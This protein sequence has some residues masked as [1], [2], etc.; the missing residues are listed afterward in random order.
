MDARWRSLYVR[1]AIRL[2]SRSSFSASQIASFAIDASLG[3]PH[4]SPGRHVGYHLVG[5]GLPALERSIAYSATLRE[6]VCRLITKRPMPAYLSL[7]A[8]LLFIVMLPA[9]V[10][11]PA[12]SPA[13]FLAYMA[14]L[15]ISAS[16]LAVSTAGLTLRSLLLP[17]PLPRMTFASGIPKSCTTVFV[18]PGMLSD[19][20]SVAKL[21]ADLEHHYLLH[22]SPNVHFGLL[23]DFLDSAHETLPEDERLLN[24][25]KTLI[26]D[27]RHRYAER[28]GS[29]ILLLH[30]R[31]QWNPKQSTWMGWERKRGKLEEF[32]RLLAGDRETSFSDVVGSLDELSDVRFVITI[33][34]DCVVPADCVR[35]MIEAAAHPLNRPAVDSASRRVSKGYGVLQPAMK[36]TLASAGASHFGLL[37]T[38]YNSMHPDSPN[39]WEINNDLFGCGRYVGK[40][41]FDVKSFL[42]V[43]SNRIP[44]N[45]L[46]SHDLFEGCLLRA[47][48]L[49]D[50]EIHE[51]FPRRF[52]SFQMRQ[53]RWI[54]GDWQVL[55]WLI[56]GWKVPGWK[57]ADISAAG[58]LILL[59]TVRGSL[60]MPAALGMFII[61]AVTSEPFGR[62]CF[63]TAVVALAAPVAVD[64]LKG[65]M[66]AREHGVQGR[67]RATT[68]LRVYVAYLGVKII[69]LPESARMSVDAIVRTLVRLVTKHQLLEWRTARQVEQQ[70]DESPVGSALQGMWFN[71]TLGSA[72]LLFL[73]TSRQTLFWL[74][75]PILVSWIAGPLAARMLGRDR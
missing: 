6:H 60:A 37:F 51:D 69:L 5:E 73:F 29:R 10:F 22:R 20:D 53:H 12:T 11:S 48:A 16:E 54:R 70:M 15:L 43:V 56:P 32:T 35:S 26:S 27:L 33:D 38:R 55:P 24:Q 36:A 2:A 13:A 19:V 17:A 50:V 64:Y 45:R 1:E 59:E 31:R 58:R 18:V 44:E 4:G 9:I 14:L 68:P 40:G 8:G 41:I 42:E 49:P 23:T 3:E 61:S 63:W 7:V 46:L 62:Y 28:A 66:P 75:L 21:A 34:E 30:R 65:R 57:F 39:G 25:A 67:G 72:G 74:A 71:V 52:S 47:A